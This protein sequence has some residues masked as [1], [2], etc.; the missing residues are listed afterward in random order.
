MEGEVKQDD[1][2]SLSSTA[3][4]ETS[5]RHP[6]PDSLQSKAKSKPVT[7]SPTSLAQTRLVERMLKLQILSAI[8]CVERFSIECRK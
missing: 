1:T 6:Q 8:I 5:S 3:T 2:E 4:S 7:K